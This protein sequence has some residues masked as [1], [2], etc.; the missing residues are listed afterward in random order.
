MFMLIYVEYFQKKPQ[1]NRMSTDFSELIRVHLCISV[2]QTKK[3]KM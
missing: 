3:E 1:I 2:V